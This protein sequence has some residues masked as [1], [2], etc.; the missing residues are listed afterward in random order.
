MAT[1]HAATERRRSAARFP[2]DTV[3]FGRLRGPINTVQKASS[4]IQAGVVTIYAGNAF[5]RDADNHPSEGYSENVVIIAIGRGPPN[6]R[7]GTPGY[8]VA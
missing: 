5:W 6:L 7:Y 3:A 1:F 2:N 4:C 8:P